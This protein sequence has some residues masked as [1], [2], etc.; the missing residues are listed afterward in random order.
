L[1]IETSL[2]YDAQSEKHKITPI[3][4][5]IHFAFIRSIAVVIH[6]IWNFSIQ[7]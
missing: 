6:W 5:S 1:V 3:S 7:S 4:I 2:Y